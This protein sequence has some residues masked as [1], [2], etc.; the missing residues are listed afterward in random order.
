MAFIL[1]IFTIFCDSGLKWISP[2]ITPF[3][4]IA[5]IISCFI[6]ISLS[7][8]FSGKNFLNAKEGEEKTAKRSF[9]FGFLIYYLLMFISQC[10]VLQVAC[11]V[12]DQIPF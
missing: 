3:I 10:I 6:P 4:N 7:I 1:K 5:A 9:G 8:Y 12:S 11:G 2:F